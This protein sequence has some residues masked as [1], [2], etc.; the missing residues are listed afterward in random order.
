MVECKIIRQGWLTL[1]LVVII[2][3]LRLSISSMICRF[4]STCRAY[5]LPFERGRLIDESILFLV[6][7]HILRQYVISGRYAALRQ[8]NARRVLDIMAENDREIKP[9]T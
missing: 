6:T 1:Y 8:H 2:S 5:L 9:G 3:H 7:S 4:I